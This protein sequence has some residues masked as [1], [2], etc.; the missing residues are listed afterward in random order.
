MIRVLVDENIPIPDGVRGAAVELTLKAGR[1]LTSADLE[2]IDAL[3]VRSVRVTWDH[4]VV[5][6]TVERASRERKP[7]REEVSGHRACRPT[8]LPR[9]PGPWAGLVLWLLPLAASV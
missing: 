7:P 9:T 4:C 6:A 5:L 1:D 3:L 8:L 2:G